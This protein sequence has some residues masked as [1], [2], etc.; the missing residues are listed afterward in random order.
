MAAFIAGPPFE[1]MPKPTPK[2]PRGRVHYNRRPMPDR[3]RRRG[4][5]RGL[6]LSRA[7]RA[8]VETM[9]GTLLDRYRRGRAGAAI[10]A[11]PA[12][13]ARRGAPP[14]PLPPPAHGL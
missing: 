13:A 6:D 4:G 14:P 7:D 9:I 8:R 10:L 3:R 12:R 5:T 11:L 1:R 2:S